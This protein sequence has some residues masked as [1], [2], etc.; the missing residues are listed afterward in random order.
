MAE[1]Q[2]DRIKQEQEK[3]DHRKGAY[4]IGPHDPGLPASRLLRAPTSAVGEEKGN[5]DLEEQT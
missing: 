4:K 5:T 3:T 2:D 1:D